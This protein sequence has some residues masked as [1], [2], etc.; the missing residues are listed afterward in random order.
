MLAC[1]INSEDL[2]NWARAVTNSI[3][4]MITC[5]LDTLYPE[6]GLATARILERAGLRV[7]FPVGQT[8]CGQ[9]A[10]NAGLHLQARRMAQHTIQVFEPEP[11]WIV[12]PSGSCTAMIRHG[13]P[14]LFRADPTWYP[15]AR[16]LAERTY[17]LSEFLVDVVRVVDL[18]AEY[19]QLIAYHPS[20][21]LARDLGVKQQPLQLLQATRGLTLI[22]LPERGDCC[23]FGGLFSI[24]HPR[25]SK[26]MLDRKIENFLQSGA[27]ML[28]ACDAGC[29]THING[30][31]HRRGLQPCA[32]HIAEVLA[33]Q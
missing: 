33:S 29:I 21:H 23:G 12:L 18:G 13:Y 10:Y 26:A 8:C 4:L 6:I 30:G 15:R 25:I 14:D 5:I 31:M 17:E 27:E 22:D 3:Q 16:A 32:K 28:V 7:S 11:G 24:E 19:N 20:C 2:L 1:G 9:P